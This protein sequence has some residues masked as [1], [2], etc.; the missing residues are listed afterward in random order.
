MTE[1][2]AQLIRADDVS[3]LVD[4]PAK[5]MDEARLQMKY[6]IQQAYSI[7]ERRFK[8]VLLFEVIKSVELPLKAIYE[9]MD[10]NKQLN[11]QNK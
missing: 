6:L 2:K 1:Y 10:I 9:Q 3:K 5:D 4:L 7:P 11:K 8:R